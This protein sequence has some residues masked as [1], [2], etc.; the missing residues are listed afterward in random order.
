MELRSQ[1]RLLVFSGSANEPLA[2]EVAHLYPDLENRE[3]F[4]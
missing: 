3:W 1:K 4:Y 2:E